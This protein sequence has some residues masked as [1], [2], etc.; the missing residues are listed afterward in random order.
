MEYTLN[1]KTREYEV[2][3]TIPSPG[4]K[5]PQKKFI[6]S[7]KTEIEAKAAVISAKKTLEIIQP[8]VPTNEEINR[9]IASKMSYPGL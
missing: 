8:K 3:I 2:Y 6:G 5:G 4:I 1:H 7:F 9:W